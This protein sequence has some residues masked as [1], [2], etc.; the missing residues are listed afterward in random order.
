MRRFFCFICFLVVLFFSNFSQ[1]QTGT[2]L[3]NRLQAADEMIEM[4]VFQAGIDLADSVCRAALQKGDYSKASKGLNLQ[5]RANTI[6]QRYSEA[7]PLLES[8]IAMG[9]AHLPQPDANTAQAHNNL[10]F[11]LQAL[12][13]PGLA[14]QNIRQALAMRREIHGEYHSSVARSYFI[15]SVVLGRQGDFME[16]KTYLDK[17][18]EVTLAVFGPESFE[19]HQPY[20]NLGVWHSKQGDLQMAQFYYE[21]ALEVAKGHLPPDHYQLAATYNNLGN[22]LQKREAFAAALVYM[23]QALA[24]NLDKHP[25]SAAI[26][27]LNIGNVHMSLSQFEA[28]AEAYQ[29]SYDTEQAIFGDAPQLSDM[30]IGQTRA[31]LKLG[32]SAKAAEN[33]RRAEAL[34]RDAPPKFG[35]MKGNLA[36][37][38][39]EAAYVE[40]DVAAGRAAFQKGVANMEQS[41]GHG[42]HRTINLVREWAM[43]EM[44]HGDPAKVLEIVENGT[45]RLFFNN[46]PE[47]VQQGNKGN[48]YTWPL[49]R[50]LSILEARAHFAQ[51]RYHDP[52]AAYRAI[53]QAIA[54]TD[55]MRTHL[56]DEASQLLI[57]D[58]GMPMYEMGLETCM[59]L[60]EKGGDPRYLA[61]A[62]G[63]MERS[64]A[65]VLSRNLR[66]AGSRGGGLLPDSLAERERMLKI[67]LARCDELLG[68]AG[69]EA[70]QQ[71]LDSTR[72]AL[73]VAYNALCE[74]LRS[75]YPA[76]Y[77]LRFNTEFP[78]AEDLKGHLQPGE[79]LLEYFW[80]KENCY[81]LAL[82]EG[83]LKAHVLPRT[84]ELERGLLQLRK[85]LVEA[86]P[87]D[88]SVEHNCRQFAGPAAYIFKEMIGPLMGEAFPKRLILVPDG[89][90]AYLPF[91]IFLTRQAGETC[92]DYAGLPYLFRETNIRYLNAGRHLALENGDAKTGE[93]LIGFAPGFSGGGGGE[94]RQ[95]LGPLASAAK[96]VERAQMAISGQ[97]YIGAAASESRFKALA[98]RFKLLHL[99]TH[100][101]VD[102]SLPA[103]SGLYFSLPDSLEDGFLHGWELMGMNFQ[104]ELAVLS[105][106]NT[107]GGKMQRGEGVMSLARDFRLA[108]CPAVIM[109]LWNANDHSTEELMGGL[110]NALDKG[111]DKDAAL[112]E[113]RLAYLAQADPL[114]SHPHYWA[115]F[116]LIG[117]SRAIKENNAAVWWWLLPGLVALLY[118]WRRNNA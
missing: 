113:S 65:F 91:E 75:A 38:Q 78:S 94:S 116:V 70:D 76:Y 85:A 47:T 73:Q 111:M 46:N 9:R 49:Q 18:L 106:C 66:M 59:A 114:Q 51:G 93:G 48:R 67:G 89:P 110:Y 10:G 105:A 39:G 33:L 82:G 55:S 27:W 60:Y 25:R 50:K 28:A 57:A 34:L 87:L 16:E 3:D 108:G 13:K 44:E 107:G 90:L 54:L 7:A 2:S 32:Q 115:G 88:R 81:V 30:L 5:A 36:A 112:R 96:E 31:C 45:E 4:G 52:A 72:F 23:K 21:K 118:L 63:I 29:K 71:R 35:F 53:F 8:S 19:A 68:Q 84:E 20:N 62:F 97:A 43:L 102:D 37:M 86:P 26:N 103:R 109:S 12:G 92:G 104:A 95:A 56:L 11:C 98:S 58:K 17:T 42:H 69:E 64:K 101:V 100:A 77:A 40:G 6:L 61:D 83:G 74:Q 79:L 1:Y 99:A 15:L 22:L 80:G 117:E 14:L 41:M 24:I